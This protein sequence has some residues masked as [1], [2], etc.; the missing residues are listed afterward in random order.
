M[1]FGKYENCIEAC[2]VCAAYCDKCATE[3]LKEDDVKMMAECIR[4]ISNEESI[5][6]M[7]D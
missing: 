1:D 6:S 5:S 3:C 7:F 4:R 2:H